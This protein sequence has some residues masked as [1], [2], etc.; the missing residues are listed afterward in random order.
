MLLT[1]MLANADA[2]DW[3]ELF[4]AIGA[5][6]VAVGA[7]VAP[8]F[9][10]LTLR[11]SHINTAK[12]EE[13][14]LAAVEAKTKTAEVKTALEVSDVAKNEKLDAI[15]E[16]QQAGN[17]IGRHT[18]TKLDANTELTQVVAKQTNGALTEA[19]NR[20]DNLTDQLKQALA[21][22]S[23]SNE[24]AERERRHN[25][26]NKAN[27]AA[28]QAMLEQARAEIAAHCGQQPQTVVVLTPEGRAEAV[29]TLKPVTGIQ[30]KEKP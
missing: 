9:G 3:V 11:Q 5:I 14:K 13:A 21:S 18:S 10:Y 4:K 1:L 2:I 29:H 17:M 7:I 6:V 22:L 15:A 19:L 26:T 28:L 20:I 30:P 8:I 16:A 23:Q 12:A 24:L 27:I 25:E